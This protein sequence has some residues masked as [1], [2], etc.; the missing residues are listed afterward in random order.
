MKSKTPFRDLVNKL[1]IIRKE[2][3]TKEQV[4]KINIILEKTKQDEETI[5]SREIDKRKIAH[6]ADLTQ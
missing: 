2:P 3:L 5:T 1:H 6:P 4:N